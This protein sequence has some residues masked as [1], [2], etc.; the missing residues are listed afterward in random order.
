MLPHGPALK[1]WPHGKIMAKRRNIEHLPLKGFGQPPLAATLIRRVR[2]WA[3][4]A[5]SAVQL[6]GQSFAYLQ[7]MQG[8]FWRAI[9]PHRNYGRTCS[10]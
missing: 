2:I 3:T 10:D 4:S 1:A 9:E 5:A 8:N 6:L 7:M